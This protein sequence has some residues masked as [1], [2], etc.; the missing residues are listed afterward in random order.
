M[1]TGTMQH[2]DNVMQRRSRT[3][4]ELNRFLNR[5]AYAPE[6]PATMLDLHLG[7]VRIARD[8]ALASVQL[9][10]EMMWGDLGRTPREVA[11][12]G[13]HDDAEAGDREACMYLASYYRELNDSVRSNRYARMAADAG[14]PNARFYMLIGTRPPPADFDE[15]CRA[16]AERG[17]S[18]AINHLFKQ[19][20]TAG[21]IDESMAFMEQLAGE[22][23]QTEAQF[24]LAL[25]YQSHY[26]AEVGRMLFWTVL[27]MRGSHQGARD[28][29]AELKAMFVPVVM[30]ARVWIMTILALQ[31]AETVEDG[32]D[33]IA[34]IPRGS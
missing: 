34:R 17:S 11:H 10:I 29:L 1:I 32:L 31:Q 27:A 14:S 21:R 9:G 30:S 23:N 25:M 2:F 18:E 12:D 13:M 20:Y 4:P 7:R 8:P 15:K 24:K 19:A 26:P 6:A 22:F 3:G 5:V 28:K 33:R 16:L